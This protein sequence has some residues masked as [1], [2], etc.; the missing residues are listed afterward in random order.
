M[1]NALSPFMCAIPIYF[2]KFGLP[3]FM[4]GFILSKH[5]GQANLEKLRMIHLN[6]DVKLTD[7]PPYVEIWA[8]TLHIVISGPDPGGSEGCRGC[9]A[10]ENTVLLTLKLKVSRGHVQS[11]AEAE[12]GRKS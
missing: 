12:E 6:L 10:T 9:Q 1:E 2:Y 8:R 7:E 3:K 4:W 5:M 11:S